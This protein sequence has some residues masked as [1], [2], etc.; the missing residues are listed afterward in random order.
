M[1][2]ADTVVLVSYAER[3]FVTHMGTLERRYVSERELVGLHIATEADALLSV[4]PVPESLRE[5]PDLCAAGIA[6]AFAEANDHEVTSDDFV[7]T[8][9]HPGPL[10]HLNSIIMPQSS[11]T[12]YVDMHCDPTPRVVTTL[13]SSQTSFALTC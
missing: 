7:R 3:S 2:A 5:R 10:A 12:H 9:H 8:P 6:D 4:P 1:P 13:R 11:P